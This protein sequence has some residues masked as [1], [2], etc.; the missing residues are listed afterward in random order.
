MSTP[1]L[2]RILDPSYLDGVV[3]RSTDE[4]RTLRAE[5]EV[6]EEGVSYVRRLLQGRL[7]LLRAETERRTD[8]GDRSTDELA[9]RLG[10]ILGGHES[11]AG[12]LQARSTRLRLPPTAAVFEQELDEIADERDLASLASHDTASLAQLV[13]RLSA[14]ERHLSGIR[15]A[16]FD[17]ID[18]VRDEL[19]QRYK[20]GRATVTDLL[21]GG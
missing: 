9:R 5:C 21:D 10:E 19:A 6:L 1:E 4:L 12:P 15:R 13:E 3:D 20:D 16:L 8:A 17:R 11:A 2:D 14:H 18:A 7:D